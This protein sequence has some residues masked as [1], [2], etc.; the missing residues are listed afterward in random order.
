MSKPMKLGFKALPHAEKMAAKKAHR[1][2][3]GK[4]PRSFASSLRIR[5]MVE[6][7][8]EQNARNGVGRPALFKRFLVSRE[9]A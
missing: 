5:D 9:V 7:M 4:L 1:A 3:L 6:G 8:R 2:Q